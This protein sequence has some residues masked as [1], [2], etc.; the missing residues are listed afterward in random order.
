M[1]FA[2]ACGVPVV[3]VQGVFFSVNLIGQNIDKD[4]STISMI[5]GSRNH[6][7]FTNFGS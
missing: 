2:Q 5:S 1:F 4:L 3:G 7:I 6:T